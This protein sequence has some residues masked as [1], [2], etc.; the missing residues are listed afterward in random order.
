[1][2]CWSHS[3]VARNA[4]GFVIKATTASEYSLVYSAVTDVINRLDSYLRVKRIYTKSCF[5]SCFTKQ[6]FYQLALLK[7][8]YVLDLGS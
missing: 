8:V 4:R 7:P 5:V 2:A 1:M 6:R 3:V